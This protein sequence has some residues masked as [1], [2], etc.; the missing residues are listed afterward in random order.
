MYEPIGKFKLFFKLFSF[1]LEL[2]SLPRYAVIAV[3]IMAGASEHG[4]GLDRRKLF[5]GEPFGGSRL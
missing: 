2:K 1:I 5:P 3:V 4:L